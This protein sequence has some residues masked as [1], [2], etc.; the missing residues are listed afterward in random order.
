MGSTGGSNEWLREHGWLLDRRRPD[1]K[2]THL[3]LDGGKARVPDESAG[4][5]L[6]AYAIA[7]VRG[8]PPSVV[9]LRTP[10]F[11]LF[12]DLDVR[13]PA[14][15]PP[16]PWGDVMRALQRRAAAFFDTADDPPRAVVC[17]TDPKQQEDGSTKAGR[18]VVWTNVWASAATALAFRAA[19]VED[20]EAALPGACSKGWA[21]V[22]DACVFTS[23]GLRMPFSAK[24]RAA[25]SVYR[26][27][28]VWVGEQPERE[29]V[30]DVRGVSAV[31]RWVRELSV[32]AFGVDET[33]VREGVH[34]PEAAA[35]EGLCGTAR[36]LREFEGVLPALEAALPA[37]FEG[38]RF[39]GVIRAEACYLLRSSSRYCGN[40]GRAHNTCNIYFVLSLKGIRQGC[41][42]RCDTLDGRR[43]GLC[44]DYRGETH[45]V[46]D[47]VL[48][49]FF[50]D[51][52]PPP[53]PP[54]LR[55]PSAKST[56]AASLQQ[57]LSRSRPA[58][59]AATRK[60]AATAAAAAAAATVGAGL[61]VPRVKR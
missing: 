46:P 3:L 14:D 22:V 15:A 13:T 61:V 54:E 8:P 17:T 51:T 23:N 57:L 35:G 56:S 5:F 27:D 37:P 59:K 28:R 60:R 45:P 44:R 33:A 11:R 50:G 19:A 34:V 10:V 20:L 55:M 52:A 18:H 49:A 42:C 6:N 25:A 12:L 16:L 9:E 2:P 43:Y 38:Q 26:P 30:G 7:V 32:R 36:S 47:E 24:G 21:Q 58:L 41:Y 53:P 40:V 31:R 29:A 48:A 4:A 39:T 1:A